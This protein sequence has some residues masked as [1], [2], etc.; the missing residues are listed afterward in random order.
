MKLNANIIAEAVGA[1]RQRWTPLSDISL[2]ISYVRALP[3]DGSRL[4]DDVLYLVFCEDDQ[5]QRRVPPQ[6]ALSKHVLYVMPST[7]SDVAGQG[8]TDDG[9]TIVTDESASDL[10]ARINALF[11]ELSA[12][13]ESMLDAIFAGV[14]ASEF[15]DVMQ[16]GLENPLCLTDGNDSLIAFSKLDF[17]KSMPPW[18]TLMERGYSPVEDM[19]AEELQSCIITP[20]NT[21]RMI[22]LA[23]WIDPSH[24]QLEVEVYAEDNVFG[25]VTSVGDVSGHSLGQA[26]LLRHACN[27]LEQLL[28]I[29]EKSGSLG[30]SSDMIL[31]SLLRGEDVPWRSVR[32]L[33]K[34]RRWDESNLLRLILFRQADERMATKEGLRFY[35]TRLRMS[36]PLA[37]VIVIGEDIAMIY[38]VQDYPSLELMPSKLLARQALGN[39][40]IAATSASFTS[41]AACHPH[42]LQAEAALDTVVARIEGTVVRWEDVASETITGILLENHSLEE[43]CHPVVLQ[44]IKAEQRHIV[45]TIYYYLLCGQNARLAARCCFI[46]PNTVRYRVSQIQS[47]WGLEFEEISEQEAFHLMVSLRMAL[48]ATRDSQLPG[49]TAH[50]T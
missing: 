9:M 30:S 36:F 42:Y 29:T 1:K 47:A 50:T 11:A 43:L 32:Q 25:R 7:R 35:L 20:E 17:D 39:H 5:A 10:L 6:L 8:I 26:A 45:E 46:H 15:L 23:L 16:D 13:D 14:T 40:S 12:W 18:R 48:E 34:G 24:I 44:L 3:T 2:D 38:R 41:I 4:E 37:N 21:N 19:T 49:E 22:E 33:L 31:L 27:R 28:S